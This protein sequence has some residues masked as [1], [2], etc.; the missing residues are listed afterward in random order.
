MAFSTLD[1]TIE[2][3]G[4]LGGRQGSCRYRGWVQ[5]KAVTL[6]Q[7]NQMRGGIGNVQQHRL[8]IHQAVMGLERR[9]H[10][11][12]GSTEAVLRHYGRNLPEG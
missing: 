7:L 10:R 5:R 8:A 3:M 6:C 11:Q 1:C 2:T 4:G 9:D 12:G